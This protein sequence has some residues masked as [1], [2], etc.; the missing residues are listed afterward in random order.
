MLLWTANKVRKHSTV[1]VV[2]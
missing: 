1:I 2:L